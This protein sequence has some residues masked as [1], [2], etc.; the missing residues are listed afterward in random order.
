MNRTRCREIPYWWCQTRTFPARRRQSVSFP[1]KVCREQN[2][3]AAQTDSFCDLIAD[4]CT[5][6]RARVTCLHCLLYQRKHWTEVIRLRSGM[7]RK[8]IPGKR[9]MVSKSIRSSDVA[10]RK[11]W[12]VYQRWGACCEKLMV[13]AERMSLD[14]WSPKFIEQASASAMNAK[15]LAKIWTD[16]KALPP[17]HSHKSPLDCLCL[18]R[19]QPLIWKRKLPAEYFGFGTT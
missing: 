13:K 9:P 7:N 8:D 1:L 6:N 15:K 18:D 12:Q 16:W 4:E 17:T 14:K 5:L 3:C 11:N 10:F 2:T 19:V